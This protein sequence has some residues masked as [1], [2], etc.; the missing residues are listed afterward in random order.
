MSAETFAAT[1]G[2]DVRG[3]D[4]LE[5]PLLL[6]QLGPVYPQEHEQEVP[7]P[8]GVTVTPDGC[9]F[10]VHT[11]HMADLAH[12]FVQN[13]QEPSENLARWELKVFE[14][15]DG[16]KIYSGFIPGLKPGDN[17]VLSTNGEYDPPRSYHRYGHQL[18]DPYARR[19]R[20]HR[21]P[22]DSPYDQFP[23]RPYSVVPENEFDWQGDKP[24][25]IAEKDRVIY[26]AHI[27]GST[28]LNEKIPKNLRGKYAGFA[29][30]ANIEHLR[31]L[32]VTTVEFLPVQQFSTGLEHT[33]ELENYWG[34]NTLGFFA[35]HEAYAATDDPVAEFK[36][37]VRKLHAAGIE[38]VLDVV[39]NHTAESGSGGPVYSF[40]GLDNEGYY[41]IDRH[42]NYIDDTGCGN[43]MNVSNSE[44]YNQGRKTPALKLV[45]DSLR[46]WV[47]DM[48]VDGYR[49]DLAPA[50]LR[51]RSQGA[52]YDTESME[53]PFIQ[54]IR[55]DP[56]LSQC[57]LIAEPWD[58]RGYMEHKGEKIGHFHRAHGAWRE[59]NGPY[60]DELRGLWVEGHQDINALSRIVG[61]LALP[62]GSIL[63]ATAHDG[64]TLRD[65][66][67]YAQKHNEANGEK[68]R[69][70]ADDNR[71]NNFGVEGETDDP[72]IRY[73]REKS[74][75]NV[76][77]TLLLSAGT[78]MMVGGD[79]SYHTQG[80]NNNAYCQNNP[81]SWR[82]WD[83]TP[84]S[85]RMRQVVST[86]I[87]AMRQDSLVGDPASL[88]ELPILRHP[89]GERPSI[90]YATDGNEMSGGQWHDGRGAVMWYRSGL[91]REALVNPEMASRV[92][93]SLLVCFN[94]GSDPVNVTLPTD[95]RAA[96][97]YGKL[98]DTAS[99]FADQD[100]TT[101]VPERFKVEPRSIVVLERQST[102]LPRRQIER[103]AQE[104]IIPVLGL[105][106]DIK[107]AT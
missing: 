82:S 100:A 60:R 68:N 26:E 105:K 43:M 72:R 40:R 79:E 71:S 29:H 18:L 28:K 16:G 31:E 76:L 21:R 8:L 64:F 75:R 52:R 91:E 85:D 90:W 32:G 93:R 103:G 37:M 102:P 20:W 44:A 53:A 99:G 94:L 73:E 61:G 74:A 69:D 25:V 39:Y 98:I 77:I 34:Y 9:K 49:F 65:L 70:G 51:D 63:L 13:P 17:Y 2:V 81:I 67:S 78:P 106:D 96:G 38:V 24:P 95:P 57:L 35:P 4:Q 62:R 92:G 5:H 15:P 14:D 83:S 54:E 59:W 56:L 10:A 87:R 1:Q 36:E 41:Q 7:Y 89:H 23:L 30:E 48:H 107:S 33:K 45:M 84:E 101:R 88:S 86:G 104:I 42:G 97:I 80:G 66:V 6:E 22:S 47:K 50:L 11:D 55:N 27:E 12:L 46:Y 19:V 58:M 3:T